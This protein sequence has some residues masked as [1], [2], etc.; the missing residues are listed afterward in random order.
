M[1]LVG[2][3]IPLFS[4]YNVF[5]IMNARES[6]RG[7][8]EI[9]MLAV[10]ITLTAIGSLGFSFVFLDIDPTQYETNLDQPIEYEYDEENQ[11]VIVTV[12]TYYNEATLQN[13][14][15]ETETVYEDPMETTLTIDAETGD[16]V[17]LLDDEGNETARWVVGEDS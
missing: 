17:I 9:G 7:Y 6:K 1:I 5:S 8:L 13:V 4:L 10:V 2:K 16:E 12:N 3:I 15:K 11:Q 14:T